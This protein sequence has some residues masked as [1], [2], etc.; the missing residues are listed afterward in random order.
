[1]SLPNFSLSSVQQIFNPLQLPIAE[2]LVLLLLFVSYLFKCIKFPKEM[3]YQHCTNRV[4]LQYK[5]FQ[6]TY[7]TLTKPLYLGS[8]FGSSINQSKDTSVFI[9][10]SDSQLE[11][12]ALEK[13]TTVFTQLK[14]NIA[15]TCIWVIQNFTSPK[16]V[17][18]L[19]V[20]I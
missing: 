5:H 14:T 18:S 7:H 6:Y 1:M 9:C 17:L 15:E 10:V 8:S 13:V 19:Y 12:S 2:E 16:A 4:Q 3:M 11:I 20:H